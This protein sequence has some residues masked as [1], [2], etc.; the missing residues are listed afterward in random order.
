MKASSKFTL[1]KDR[2]GLL[3]SGF[4]EVQGRETAFTLNRIVSTIGG[5]KS[6]ALS[7]I[8]SF[9]SIIQGFKNKEKEYVKTMRPAFE[10]LLTGYYVTYNNLRKTQCQTAEDI[11]IFDAFNFIPLE[12]QHSKFLI[13]LFKPLE[14]HAQENLFFKIFLKEVGLPEEYAQIDYKVKP[15]VK[16]KESRI[17]IEIMSKKGGEQGFIIHIENKVGIAPNREQIEK[18]NRDLEKKAKAMRIHENR[19]HG[20]LL[21]VVE[22]K[23]IPFKWIG[24]DKIVKCL[25]TFINEAKADR[26]KWAAE[27]YLKCIKKNILKVKIKPKEEEAR[28]E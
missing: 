7:T 27:Q 10:R 8:N 15:E 16:H 14:T 11:N 28:N 4:N 21:S 3:L 23:D 22:F 19:K 26:A 17:D 1:T 13:W 18:E 5:Y 20:F 9:E 6:A 12:T 25:V 24:W 2:I